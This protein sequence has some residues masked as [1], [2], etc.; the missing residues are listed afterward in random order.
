[1]PY[2]C[3]VIIALVFIAAGCGGSGKEATPASGTASLNWTAPTT[4]A[5]GSPLLDLA[6]FRVYYG[7]TTGVYTSSVTV[8]G[9]ASTSYSL[10]GMAAGDY[11]MAVTA[12]DTSGNE[13]IKSE[14]VPKTVN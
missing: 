9:P 14:E 3:L 10:S 12:Y 13:S 6:G 11:Y 2:R 8:P 7:T 5:D 1:V 4:N